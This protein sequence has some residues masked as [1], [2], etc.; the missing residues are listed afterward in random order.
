MRE[1]RAGNGVLTRL[2]AQRVDNGAVTAACLTPAARGATA[3]C[4]LR[5]LLAGAV[6][7][8]RSD[9]GFKHVP[10]GQAFLE[11]PALLVF[12]IHVV[13]FIVEQT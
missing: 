11:L 8:T 4:V 2:I 10:D 3:A 13:F 9:R 5:Q 6:E 7:G 12:V 1:K